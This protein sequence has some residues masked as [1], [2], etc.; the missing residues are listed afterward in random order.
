MKHLLITIVCCL[1][2]AAAVL[3]IDHGR[4]KRIAV[5]DAI[6][7][8]NSFKMKIEME[9]AVDTKLTQL[10]KKAD[11]IK[12]DLQAKASMKDIA[13]QE[14]ERVYGLFM[15]AQQ[16]LEREY[17]E[18]NRDINEQVWKRLNPLI[19]EYAKKENFRVVIGANGMGSVLYYDSYYDKTKACIE[20]V[21]KVYEGGN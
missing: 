14:V 12:Q 8:F 7:V 3:W 9:A 15:S 4:H 13:R 21:N 6:Q 19:D 20:Y 11:S 16:E 5:V 1:M 2:T 18:S 17:E 10:G